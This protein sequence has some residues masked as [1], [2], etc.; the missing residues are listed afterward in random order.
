MLLSNWQT[1]LR[2]DENKKELFQFLSK[3]LVQKVTEKIV[4]ATDN[5]GV[6]N[7]NGAV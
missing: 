7:N 3:L 4:V 1:F 6:V 2:C 5:E